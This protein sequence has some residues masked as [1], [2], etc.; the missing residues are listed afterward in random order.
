MEPS[1][2]ITV[3]KEA[4]LALDKMI[5]T[6]NDKFTSGKVQKFQLASSIILGFAATLNAKTIERIRAEHFDKVAHV[7]SI[8][9][10]LEE[11]EK[12]KQEIELDELLLPLKS[13]PPKTPRQIQAEPEK[14]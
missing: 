12:T 13:K 2:K 11:A 9:K 3:T 5:K 6:I 14:D 8:L 7:R 4:D 1:P 10:Q